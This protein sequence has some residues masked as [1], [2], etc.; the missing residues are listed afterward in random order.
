MPARDR[1]HNNV[2]NAL[3]KD[4]WPITHDPYRLVVQSWTLGDD[5]MLAAEKDGTNIA[6]QRRWIDPN[7]EFEDMSQT[8][9][10]Y[11]LF[12][13]ALQRLDPGRTLFLAISPKTHPMLFD[14]SLLMPLL[15]DCGLHMLHF[16]EDVHQAN[17]WI[18]RENA[19]RYY[20]EWLGMPVPDCVTPGPEGPG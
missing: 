13:S 5:N 6:V 10:Q 16:S 14:D 2:K 12:Q 1:Y 3:V 17:V 11:L 4:G 19:R 8:V 18:Q 9:G 15:G 7:S 20:A